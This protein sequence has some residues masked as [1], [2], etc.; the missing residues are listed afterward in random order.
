M[1][2]KYETSSWGY[3]FVVP[4]TTNTITYTTYTNSY[5]I[6][7]ISIT[8]EEAVIEVLNECSIARNGKILMP[9]S[10]LPKIMCKG[11]KKYKC[12]NWQWNY[13]FFL[14]GVP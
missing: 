9:V 7:V 8:N 10:G 13:N 2:H 14:L 12:V 5:T 3:I 1:K 6:K 4:Y 11:Y